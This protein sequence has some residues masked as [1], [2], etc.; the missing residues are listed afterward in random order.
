MTRAEIATMARSYCG[1]CTDAACGGSVDG[2]YCEGVVRDFQRLG[3]TFGPG[4]AA[5]TLAPIPTTTA[6]GSGAVCTAAATET[7]LTSGAGAWTI[8]PGA[9]APGRPLSPLFVAFMTDVARFTTY[10]PILTTGTNHS[11]YTVDVNVSDHYAGNAGDFSSE[12]NGFGTDD[13]QPGQPVPRGDELAAA[14]L[15]AAG[16]AAPTAHEW[17]LTGG[18]RNVTFAFRA[19]RVRLQVIWKTDEGGNHHNHV[20]IGVQPR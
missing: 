16:I 15:I 12:A 11:K 8:A 20:H 1:S 14:A 3:G 5:G 13:A 4:T 18:L 7:R 2:G 6:A 10:R 19:Q 9:N 17:A